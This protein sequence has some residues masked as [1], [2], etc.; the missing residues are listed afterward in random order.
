[1]NPNDLKDAERGRLA[2]E[3]LNNPVYAE[4]RDQIHAEIIKKWREAS[5]PETREHLHRLQ[6]CMSKLDEV[7][8]STMNNGKVAQKAL[9]H[10]ARRGLISRLTST[11]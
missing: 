1:M 10:D 8:T 9:E 11:R 4:A 7:L 2:A 3:V 6:K 5:D